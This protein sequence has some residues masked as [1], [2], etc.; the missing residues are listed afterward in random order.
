M[1]GFQRHILRDFRLNIVLRRYGGV[2]L[3]L[4][5]L[6]FRSLAFANDFGV[7]ASLD[8]YDLEITEEGRK[9]TTDKFSQNY[10]LRYNRDI[11]P[12]LLYGLYLR[13]GIID[14][15]RTD[16]EGLRNKSTVKDIEP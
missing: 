13:S 4:F 6:L 2:I 3:T 12:V 1:N 16:F 9:T 5:F 11:T 10:Y 14:T 7:S 15:T 8:Y